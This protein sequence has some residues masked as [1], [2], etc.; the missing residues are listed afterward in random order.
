MHIINF[1]VTIYICKILPFTCSLREAFVVIRKRK[2][3]INL[4]KPFTHTPEPAL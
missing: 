2:Y 3:S 1:I 4:H